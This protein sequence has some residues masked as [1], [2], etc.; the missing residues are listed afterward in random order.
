[1]SLRI[2]AI[3]P[4]QATCRKWLLQASLTPLLQYQLKDKYSMSHDLR[5]LAT[6]SSWDAT[7]G[8]CRGACGN[9][10]TGIGQGPHCDAIRTLEYRHLGYARATILRAIGL[11][12][13]AQQKRRQAKSQSSTCLA[14]PFDATQSIGAKGEAARRRLYYSPR[15]RKLFRLDCPFYARVECTC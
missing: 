4:V 14:A 3:K 12:E 13:K 10:C 1:M 6:E 9:T 5:R 2:A 15:S 8:D 11:M 7:C